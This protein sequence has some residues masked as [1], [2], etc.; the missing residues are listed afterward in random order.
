MAAPGTSPPPS[1]RSSS[2]TPVARARAEERST[3]PI[4][5]ATCVTFPGTSESFF[6]AASSS[7]LPH[8]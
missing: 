4:G 3:S 7:T 8:A 1:T 5:V 2:D 6:G